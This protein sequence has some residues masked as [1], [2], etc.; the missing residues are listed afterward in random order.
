MAH[1]QE[2]PY[3]RSKFSP[4]NSDRMA[5]FAIIAFPLH[6]LITIVAILHNIWTSHVLDDDY[7]LECLEITD[8]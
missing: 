3:H 4:G 1:E 8:S 5:L 2:L 7:K 6:S